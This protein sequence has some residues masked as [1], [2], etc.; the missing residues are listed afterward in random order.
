MANQ[1]TPDVHPVWGFLRKSGLGQAAFFV[2]CWA[3]LSSYFMSFIL[4]ACCLLTTRLAWVFFSVVL[5]EFLVYLGFKGAQRELASGADLTDQVKLLPLGTG[6]GSFGATLVLTFAFYI[7]N[8]T[9]PWFIARVRETV[10]SRL[11][12]PPFP[13][14]TPPPPTPPFTSPSPTLHPPA[15]IRGRA[16]RVQLHDRVPHRGEHGH[17]APHRSTPQ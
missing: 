15:S 7:L 4:A 5:F 16:P 12:A 9:V 14:L 8:S 3:F 13:C 17:R 2:S 11:G 10:D 1:Q 6:G